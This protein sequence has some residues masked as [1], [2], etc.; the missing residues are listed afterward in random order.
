MTLLDPFVLLAFPRR[1]A[2]RRV[3]RVARAR[4]LIDFANEDGLPLKGDHIIFGAKGAVE[5]FRG[6]RLF[7][8]QASIMRHECHGILWSFVS[9]PGE[10]G[11]VARVVAEGCGR[12]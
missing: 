1:H 8:H 11:A 6:V 10:A 9:P 5:P 4:V 3:K 12:I 2:A 7:P